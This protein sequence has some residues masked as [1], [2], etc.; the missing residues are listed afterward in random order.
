VG[1]LTDTPRTTDGA[2]WAVRT[3]RLNEE[4]CGV[5]M[6][7]ADISSSTRQWTGVSMT[8][9]L[10]RHAGLWTLALM[11]MRSSSRAAVGRGGAVA[12]AKGIRGTGCGGWLGAWSQRGPHSSREWGRAPA[13]DCGQQKIDTDPR[14]VL[15]SGRQTHG[16]P[17][18]ER[19]SHPVFSPKL[20]A[21]LYVCQDDR[22]FHTP[23][24]SLYQST[25]HLLSSRSL[26]QYARNMA[27]VST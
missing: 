25:P 20:N 7:E 10:Q 16:A 14:A 23:R 8:S 18:R 2:C 13:S 5:L 4:L 11:R 9:W 1:G 26:Q 12:P 15:P 3:L 24:R 6:K 22:G 21:F 19:V 27:S 17:G